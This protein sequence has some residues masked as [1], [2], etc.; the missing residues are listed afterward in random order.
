MASAVFD[1][2]PMDE[3]M[4]KWCKRVTA[5]DV[6]TVLAGPQTMLKARFTLDERQRPGRIDY[7]N[8]HGS[9]KGRTQAGIFAIDRG[10]LKI[11]MAAPGQ[12]R[13]A[14]FAS[15]TGDGRSFTTWRASK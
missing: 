12:P 11:C 3:A 1:G 4:V 8:L 5:G 13:P 6:T 7:V 15:R 10:V 2:Q 14:E 9:N